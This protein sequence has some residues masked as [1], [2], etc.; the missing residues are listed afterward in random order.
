MRGPFGTG[1]PNANDQNDHAGGPNAVVFRFHR[2]CRSEA[3]R[4][5]SKLSIETPQQRRVDSKRQTLPGRADR[6]GDVP[7]SKRMMGG[8]P[9]RTARP[10]TLA[11]T[12]RAIPGA[13]NRARARPGPRR[14]TV[15]LTFVSGLAAA[16]KSQRGEKKT[17]V[18]A[19]K[20]PQLPVGSVPK[21]DLTRS[22]TDCTAH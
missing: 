5:P 11:Q 18:E 9:Q 13:T 15:A 3:R 4:L 7:N 6:A 22:I 20:A 21:T 17:A 12:P 8:F 14:N 2:P 1:I 19:H 16:D 10:E